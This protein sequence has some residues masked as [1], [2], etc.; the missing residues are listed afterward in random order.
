V[1]QTPEKFLLLQYPVAGIW[2][3]AS[4]MI[5]CPFCRKGNSHKSPQ[6]ARGT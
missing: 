5:S 3:D 4:L 2:K 1:P 6:P